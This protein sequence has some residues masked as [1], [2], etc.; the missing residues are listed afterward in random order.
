MKIISLNTWGGKV[1]EPLRKFL[2]E[3]S[4]TIDIFC[5]QEIFHHFH[6]EEEDI[7]PELF[8]M[9][10]TL[11]P[12]HHG[13]FLPTIDNTYGLAMF[14]YKDIKVNKQ[15]QVEIYNPDHYN[16]GPN[17]RRDIQSVEV[18][19]KNEEVLNV[20]NIHGLWNGKGKG[21][22]PERIKQSQI[23]KSHIETLNNRIIFCGDFNLLPTT[24]SI[25]II[26]ETGLV[27]LITKYGITST[28]TS[29]YEKPEKFADYFFISPS[30]DIRDFQVLPD[31]VSDHSALYLEIS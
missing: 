15:E 2:T 12:N 11:L 25:S 30:L 9:I 3:K 17:F 6:K 20:I 8:S 24:Q 21:D 19:L 22:F 1:D 13:Y 31:E 10:E 28:R 5:F 27:N 18:T 29:Y 26:E 16:G 23:I 14:V 7:N 4:N